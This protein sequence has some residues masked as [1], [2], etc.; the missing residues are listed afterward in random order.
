MLAV[1]D[2]YGGVRIY[3][4]PCARHP[5]VGASYVEVRGPHP[6]RVTSVRWSADDR[7]LYTLGG[8][9]RLVAQWRVVRDD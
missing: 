2:D 3:R 8:G 7:T 6:R 4:W 9:D 1:A 5:R